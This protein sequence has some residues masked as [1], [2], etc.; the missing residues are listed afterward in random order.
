ME[1]S[2]LS[3]LSPSAN[4]LPLSNK[5]YIET[6]HQE[7]VFKVVPEEILVRIFDLLKSKDFANGHLVCR[8]WNR[9]L[10]EEQLTLPHRLKQC[11]ENAKNALRGI[12][13]LVANPTKCD[14][15]NAF[16]Y[17]Y[18]THAL[19]YRNLRLAHAL[20]ATGYGLS[21][22]G[23]KNFRMKVKQFVDIDIFHDIRDHL[24]NDELTFIGQIEILSKNIANSSL[25]E[26]L[27]KITS[28][29]EKWIAPATTIRIKGPNII[30]P[31]L[32]EQL[33]EI[34][35]EGASRLEAIKNYILDCCWD[36]KKLSKFRSKEFSVFCFEDRDLDAMKMNLVRIRQCFRLLNP[37]EKPVDGD[38]S[39]SELFEF[40]TN[41]QQFKEMIKD[42]QEKT[43]ECCK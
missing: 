28:E 13:D 17:Y 5:P 35:Y 31:S 11:Y 21:K 30:S 19:E 14:R 32:K 4:V 22:E 10:K 40:V 9:I 41:L 23:R 42:Y 3:N 7:S 29:K 20:T 34:E 8:Q 38:I 26:Q 18:Y 37:S 25:F 24:Y 12:K 43:L 39:S 33:S 6:G 2:N 27:D 36:I 15:E 1:Q 16:E